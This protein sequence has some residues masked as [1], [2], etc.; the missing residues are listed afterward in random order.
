MNSSGIK[1]GWAS[2]DDGKSPLKIV[3]EQVKTQKQ[4]S[5]GL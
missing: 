2:P 1:I 5:V 4:E 3:E